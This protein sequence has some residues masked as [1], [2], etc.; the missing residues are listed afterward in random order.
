[1]RPWLFL[2][3]LPACATV[4][5]APRAPSSLDR[6]AASMDFA[7]AGDEVVA[8]LSD[9]L[10]VDTINPPGNETRGATF[11]AELLAK[12]GITS[13]VHEFAPGPRLAGGAALRHRPPHREAAVPALAPRRGDRRTTP[14][15]PPTR[16]RSR[17]W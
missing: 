13:T 16:S 12:E 3:L 6:F 2:L 1:M 9:Y 15:G 11:F 8:V 14:T 10:Q 5:P 4:S 17:A 7:K